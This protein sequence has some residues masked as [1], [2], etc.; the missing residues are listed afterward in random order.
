MHNCQVLWHKLGKVSLSCCHGDKVK[1]WFGVALNLSVLCIGRHIAPTHQFH[2]FVLK[3]S[4]NENT[5]TPVSFLRLTFIKNY[6]QKWIVDAELVV[7]YSKH[8]MQCEFP[9]LYFL[10]CAILIDPCFNKDQVQAQS[11]TQ[12]TTLMPRWEDWALSPAAYLALNGSSSARTANTAGSKRGIKTEST[13]E[14][15]VR[16]ETKKAKLLGCYFSA[17]SCCVPLQRE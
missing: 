16:K 9:L 1:G 15:M 7:L 13:E 4:W 6:I 5:S 17:Q 3:N 8:A 14:E 11:F 10:Y 2:R 12:Q